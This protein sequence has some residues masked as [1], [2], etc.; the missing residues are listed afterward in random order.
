MAEFLACLRETLVAPFR[1]DCGKI[2]ERAR[3]RLA[4]Q[5]SYR[6]LRE[7]DPFDEDA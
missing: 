1:D 4:P 2:I 7:F 5:A 6:N 3:A